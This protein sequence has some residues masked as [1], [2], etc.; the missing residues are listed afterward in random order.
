MVIGTAAAQGNGD[1]AG[2]APGVVNVSDTMQRTVKQ[3][4]GSADLGGAY[5]FSGAGSRYSVRPGAASIGPVTPG[6]TRGV[7]LPAVSAT[8]E[9][10]AAQ[11]TLPRLAGT[12]NGT[13]LSLQLRRTSSGDNYFARARIAGDGQMRVSLGKISHGAATYFNGEVA[14]PGTFQ[15]DDVLNLEG[16]IAGTQLSARAWLAGAATPGWQS[17]ASDTDA[18]LSEAGAV[19]I[20]VYQSGASPAAMVRLLQLQGWRLSGAAST[21]SAAPTTTAP[22]PTTSLSTTAP[23]PPST[24]SSD[25]TTTTQAAS[26]AASTTTTAPAPPPPAQTGTGAVALGSTAYA[27]PASAVFVSTTGNDSTGSGSISAPYRTLA[28][29]VSAAPSGATIVM[30]A[31]SY[32]E[33]VFVGKTLTI[34]NYPGETVWLDG[35]IPVTGFTKSGTGWVHSGWPYQ[36]DSSA[37]YSR[38]SN[39][40]GFV[41]PAYPLA[42]HPDQVFIDGRQLDQVAANPGANQFAVDYAK[43]TITVGSDPTGHSVRASN[44][45]KALTV[46]GAGVTIRGIGVHYYATSLWQMG[47]VYVGGTGGDTLSNLV[48]ADNATQGIGTDAVNLKFDHLSMLRNGMTGIQMAYSSGSVV[49]NSVMSGNNTQHFNTAPASAGIKVARM[50]D[51]TI[52]DNVVT[53][54]LSTDGIWTDENVE[55]F[56]ITGNTV[57]DNGSTFGIINELSDTGIVADNTIYNTDSGYTAMDAGNVAVYNNTFHGNSRWDVGL[58][59]DNRYQPGRSTANVLPSAADPWIVRNIVV[60]NNDFSGATGMFQFYSLDKQTNRSADVMHITID[61]NL[62]RSDV[63]S[64]DPQMIGWGGND[65]HTVTIY[66]TA[67][68]FQAA[69]GPSWTNA[70]VA[71]QSVARPAVA[72]YAVPLPADVAAAVGQATGTLHVGTF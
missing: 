65:N 35:S 17:T 2:A 30:R 59:Q 40:G 22:A 16:R 11:F 31:G 28:H 29:A 38:G 9:D 50:H 19:G 27:Y 42:A 46:G 62:F 8:D 25:A 51:I 33:E 69:K 61:G 18:A 1:D 70:S 21:T 5:A 43:A 23:P 57:G 68:A 64:T 34:Q 52:R 12:G 55:H 72:S 36:F 71:Y 37:S 6:V 58:S 10:L 4:L 26:S 63:A 14:V 48:I 15:A 24:T 45:Q 44:K 3:G 49:S 66:K 32:N 54:N 53:G 56:T 39:A 7:T 47:T 13:Y 20:S 41:N 67:A 60:A